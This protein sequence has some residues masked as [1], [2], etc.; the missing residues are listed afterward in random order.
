ML[1]SNLLL[2]PLSRHQRAEHRHTHRLYALAQKNKGQVAWPLL[3]E[4][5]GLSFNLVVYS[6]YVGVVL[7]YSFTSL[8]ITFFFILF[9]ITPIIKAAFHNGFGAP[10]RPKSTLYTNNNNSFI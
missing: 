5:I 3:W 8:F 6:L 1:N 9:H 2:V 4:L 10:K 7:F